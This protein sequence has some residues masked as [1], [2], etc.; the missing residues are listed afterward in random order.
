MGK[1]KAREVQEC[2]REAVQLYIEGQGR[3]IKKGI[4]EQRLKQ[5]R[6][7]GLQIFGAKPNGKTL[8]TEYSW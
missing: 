4:F 3:L 5:V 7:K 6:K 2:S 8:E 1:Y